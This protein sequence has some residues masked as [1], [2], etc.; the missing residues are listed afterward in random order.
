MKLLLT[1]LLFCTLS[2]AQKADKPKPVSRYMRDMGILYLETV[3]E[4]TPDCGRKSIQDSDCM[5]RWES[6]TKSIEDR[7]DIALND[8]TQR[9]SPGDVPYWNLLKNVKYA[10]KLYA[11]IDPPQR[12]AWSDAYIACYAYAHTVA[13]EG[14]YFNGDGGCNDAIGAATHQ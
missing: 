5:S 12:K 2:L 14:D 8:R 11:T 7:I 4:L 13:I 10:R 3:E 9:H 6:A 1:I